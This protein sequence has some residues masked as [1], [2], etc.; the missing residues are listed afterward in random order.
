MDTGGAEREATG[1]DEV[2]PVRHGGWLRAAVLG[3][4][5]GIVSTAAL[6]VG[7]AASNVSPQAVL[8]AG[9]AG[10]VAGATS[11]AAG[12]YV[13]VS[14]QRDVEQALRRR[15]EGR[16]GRLLRRGRHGPAPGAGRPHAGAPDRAR[17]GLC[18]RVLVGGG[19]A[20]AI[21]AVVGRLVGIVV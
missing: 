3:A 21:A 4:D 20:M 8:T 5:D 9:L 1:E 12:E 15:E 17:R 2:N 14:T 6:I 7:V 18:L 19:L 11:M 13:S 10:L 16:V